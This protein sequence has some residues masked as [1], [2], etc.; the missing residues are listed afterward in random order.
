MRRE[1][2]C[3]HLVQYDNFLNLFR[4]SNC[5]GN[6][7]TT[8]QASTDPTEFGHDD[9]KIVATLP[10]A[11]PEVVELEGGFYLAALNSQLDGIR[12]T[13]LEFIEP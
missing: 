4:T 9:A 5:R 7:Q 8:L 13:R 3:P 11:V 12:L 6:P 2:E 10:V 1:A